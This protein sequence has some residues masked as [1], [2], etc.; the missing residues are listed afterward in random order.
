MGG[1]VNDIQ[2]DSPESSSSSCMFG[3]YKKKNHI[4]IKSKMKSK[5][6]G[7]KWS[8]VKYIWG[9]FSPPHRKKK[10]SFCVC[11][12]TP[13]CGQMNACNRNEEKCEVVEEDEEDD[14]PQGQGWMM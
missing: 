13:K 1:L 10:E 6:S 12:L 7:N 3:F 4:C 8:Y 5:V 2:N 11:V 9:K 14:V